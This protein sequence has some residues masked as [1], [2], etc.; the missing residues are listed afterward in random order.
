MRLSYSKLKDFEICKKKFFLNHIIKVPFIANEA[1]EAGKKI[2]EILYDSTFQI[3]WKDWLISHPE[4]T[5]FK[6][7][8][9]NYITYQS[10]IVEVGGSPVPFIREYK[11]YDTELDFSAIIDRADYHNGKV[12]LSDYKSDGKANY[13]KHDD[14][15]LIYSYLLSRQNPSVKV[16]Y[17]AP[18]FLKHDTMIKPKKLT[19]EK[20]EKSVKWML[21]MKKE[22]ENCGFDEKNFPASPGN[23]CGWCSHHTTG[24]C[25]EGKK[26]MC[27]DVNIVEMGEDDEILV[28]ISTEN[29]TPQ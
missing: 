14:Q 1:M 24:Y 11:I 25:E 6:D 16:D 15:L 2:H 13:S 21:D 4:Y 29:S 27:N 10:K 17:Y 22:I 18:F 9:D 26:F 8:I 20:Q 3:N 28:K 19:K 12:L 7:M 5:T 23:L